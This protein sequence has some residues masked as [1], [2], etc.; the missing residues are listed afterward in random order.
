LTAGDQDSG[1]PARVAIIGGG[2][3][4][5]A[6]AFE[7]TRPE[8]AGKYEVTI[9]QQGFRMGGKGASGRG[10]GNR[11]EEHG[12]HLW[13][14]FYENAFRL[15]R[16][17]YTELGRDR[18]ACPIADW[19][20]AFVPDNFCGAMDR[21][22]R[23]NWLPWTTVFPPM[24]G[25]PGD[26]VT[27]P[28]WTVADYLNRS[29][30]LALTL[31]KAIQS[32]SSNGE[33]TAPD[34][35]TPP[36]D[37]L[38]PTITETMLRWLRYGE[39]ASLAGLI[40][41]MQILDAVVQALPAYPRDLIL[42]FHATIASAAQRQLHDRTEANDDVRRLWEVVDLVLATVRGII[43][44]GLI[45][46]PRGFE[47][48]DDYDCREWL[49]LNGA[50][51]RSVDSAFVRALYDLAFGY[52][53][54]DVTRPRI[55]A[56]QALRGA[57][58]A[59]F[60][61]RGAFFWKMQAGMGDVVFAPL[62]EVLRRRGARVEFFHRLRNVGLATGTQLVP[63][64]RPHVK[65]L[66]FDIQAELVEGA[67]YQPL[68]DVHGL[69]CWPSEPDYRQLVEG[70]R[71]RED[72]VQLESHWETRHAGSKTL[73]VGEHFDFVVLAVGL[74]AVPHVG[75]EL[76][77]HS[78]KWRDMVR[79]CKSVATQ[80]L[81]IWMNATT[82]ELGWQGPP[83]NISGFVEPFDT[84]ADMT[85]L[86]KV[87]DLSP[88]PRSIAYFCSVLPDPPSG[89]DT[90]HERYPADRREEVRKNAV[91]FLNRDVV[92]LWPNAV[93]ASRRFRW[94]L[95]WAPHAE[96]GDL[97]PANEARL[98]SQF[99]AANVNPTDR[100][101]LALPGTLKYRISPLDNTFDNLTVA[102]DWTDCGFN[103]GCVEAA[104]MSGRLAAHAIAKFPALE[105]IPGYDHP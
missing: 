22:P 84:W 27:R 41:A 39:L 20:D 38:P 66:D 92:H 71:L 90:E 40:Q 32:R 89:I 73:T 21:S 54:G 52:E 61:Y 59:F 56:G 99:W 33:S 29:V 3:A 26:A 67:E 81:Q 16:D 51:Q 4:G 34:P 98:R 100:Y 87:E 57:V 37:A 60:T 95:L 78:A 19:R 53:N 76:I 63:G 75:R 86:A 50:A 12:L 14:G 49:K 70:E 96:G 8:L 9:Y 82:N 58:R 31:L 44:F 62:Y 72:R 104:V 10:T 74:G 6:A 47:A 13:M 7:L 17:C 103:E 5:A 28:G 46:D 30:R 64:E 36:R 85:H 94:D 68:V 88:V 65:Q 48:I 23:G 69:P 80:A 91:T 105:D 93:D 102:G 79:E 35:A 25:D 83:V 11:I 18:K 42:Q 45:A 101:S 97:L 15:M 2:C 55:A 1:R 24:P 43:R 77:E